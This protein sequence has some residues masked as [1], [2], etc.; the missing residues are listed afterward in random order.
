MER[1]TAVVSVLNGTAL[2][3]DQHEAM[4]RIQACV[5]ELNGLVKML[6]TQEVETVEQHDREPSE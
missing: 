5:H 3:V 4:G 2:R 6:E 1:L